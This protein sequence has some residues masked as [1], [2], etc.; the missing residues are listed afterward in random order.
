[1]LKKILSPKRPK[2][3][4]IIRHKVRVR[5]KVR[6]KVFK[7]LAIALAGIILIG[8]FIFSL[9]PVYR[10]AS[11]KIKSDILTTKIKSFDIE[12]GNE[13]VNNEVLELFADKIGEKWNKDLSAA[14]K[15]E[16][17]LK[18]PYINSVRVSKNILT[19]KVV[20]SGKLEKIVSKITLNNEEYYLA[21]SGR[22]FSSAYEE[23]VSQNFIRAEIF[24]EK[25]AKLKPFAKFINEINLSKEIFKL[26]PILVKYNPDGK[27]CS[28]VL[29]D[30]SLVNWGKFELT[31]LKILRLNRVLADAAGKIPAPHKIDLN[32]FAMGK[33]FISKL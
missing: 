18:H 24:S 14:I 16:L 28:L 8:I 9:K 29:E 2:K 22:V 4:K 23:A 27:V 30:N 32:H 25:K 11:T 26:K 5:V 19:G 17:L 7:K 33:I 21:L 12:I 10:F 31:D 15:E 1:M 6:K 20:I 3:K 13:R